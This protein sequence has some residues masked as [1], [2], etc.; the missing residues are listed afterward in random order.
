MWIFMF[1]CTLLPFWWRFCQC[2]NKFHETGL[3]VHLINTGKYF[4]K[5]I[6][7][8][9][10]IFD[11]HSGKV[12]DENFILFLI[13]NLIATCYC[14]SW[15]YYMDWG[16]IRCFDKGKYLLRKMLTFKPTTY[17]L[18]A[19]VNLLLRFSWLVSILEYDHDKA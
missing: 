15:D 1:L 13:F 11:I 19:L 9:I 14:T 17:Y 12:S 7:P 18:A 5:M 3:K 4:S 6:P 10:V 2:L 16:M 8:I